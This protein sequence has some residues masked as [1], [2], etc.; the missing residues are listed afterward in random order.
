[1]SKEDPF[2]SRSRRDR[3]MKAV[4]AIGRQVNDI[5]AKTPETQVAAYAIWN[6]LAIIHMNLVEMPKLNSN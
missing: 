3:I 1:M 2:L 4:E 5:A 6:N